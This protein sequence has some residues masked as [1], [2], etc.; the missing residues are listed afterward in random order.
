VTTGA[1]TIAGAKTFTSPVLVPAGTAAL[2]GLPIGDAAD[3]F[4]AFSGSLLGWVID[5]QL[6][7]LLGSNAGSYVSVSTAYYLGSAVGNTDSGIGRVAAGVTGVID[8]GTTIGSGSLRARYIEQVVGAAV[9]SAT[10]ITLTGGIQHVT[11]T[12]PIQT[13]NL[14]RVGF[15]GCVKL[16]PDAVWTLT[17]G[18]NIALASTAVVS[19]VMEVCYDGTSWFPSY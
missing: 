12:T 19:R 5:G 13:I 10:T 6:R 2:P 1:Q 7:G 4:Y 9:A 11:G 17:T 16:I 14:P 8:S 3:G 15:T 18:G